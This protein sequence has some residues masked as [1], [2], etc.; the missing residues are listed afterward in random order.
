M[1]AG[2]AFRTFL[3]ASPRVLV[4]LATK[5]L[6]SPGWEAKIEKSGVGDLE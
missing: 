1:V 3:M 6:M 2:P 5:L 4:G